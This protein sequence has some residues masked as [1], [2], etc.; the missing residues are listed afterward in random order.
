[1]RKEIAQIALIGFCLILIGGL[2]SPAFSEKSDIPSSSRKSL[3]TWLE[4]LREELDDTTIREQNDTNS[5]LEEGI[6]RAA[7]IGKIKGK[8]KINIR[9]KKKKEVEIKEKDEVFWPKLEEYKPEEKYFTEL[10]VGV[11]VEES[12]LPKRD[13][14]CE[15]L[16]KELDPKKRQ[17]ENLA[18]DLEKLDKERIE[19]ETK[20][21]ILE[22]IQ[23]VAQTNFEVWKSK[24]RLQKFLDKGCYSRMPQ[25]TEE[26][27]VYSLY[28]CW[29]GAKPNI[30]PLRPK[31][32]R[33]TKFFERQSG[34]PSPYD[35][36]PN[37][38]KP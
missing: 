10:C 14:D 30:A 26:E 2:T 5:F 15:A 27:V 19:T 8:L 6:Q 29:D 23:A 17:L 1:M 37:V 11:E 22:Q 38:V 7:K 18:E 25:G 32:K 24:I 4:L 13:A 31:P 35:L 9:V 16:K 36:D 28:N 12:E 33:G 3:N 34:S 21:K 20:I